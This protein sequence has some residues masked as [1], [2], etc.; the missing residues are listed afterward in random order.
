MKVYHFYLENLKIPF[1]FIL[2]SL[3]SLLP[4]HSSLAI[5]II[6]VS[7]DFVLFN[8]TTSTKALIETDDWSNYEKVALRNFSKTLKKAPKMESLLC[9]ITGVQS[10]TS[11]KRAPSLVFSCKFWEIFEINYS[12][13]HLWTFASALIKWVVLIQRCIQNPIKHLTWS[14][15]RRWLMV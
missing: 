2:M 4:F 5:F 8:I 11:I 7:Y 13:E 12:L 6:V 9:K 15:L 3:S 14:L 1:K 10:M